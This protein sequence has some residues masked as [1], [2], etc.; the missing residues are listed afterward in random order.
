[1]I[2]CM[3]IYS[4]HVQDHNLIYCPIAPSLSKYKATCNKS[5]SW[6]AH[7]LLDPRL[8][9]SL[10]KVIPILVLQFQNDPLFAAKHWLFSSKRPLFGDKTLT[11]HSKMNC[12]FCGETLTFQPK[13]THLFTVKHCDIKINPFFSKF[14]E[15]STKIPPFS[16]KMWILDVLKKYAFI[17]EF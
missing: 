5:E 17:H 3:L 4:E 8:P 2:S 11:F 16:R 7:Y 15:V 10:E 6:Q 1:M 13:W 12:L 14:T 9:H